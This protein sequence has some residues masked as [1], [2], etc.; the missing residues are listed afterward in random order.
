VDF[1]LR[2]E[3]WLGLVIIQSTHADTSRK[4]HMKTTR[5]H[6]EET[7]PD[8]PATM[9]RGPCTTP[10]SSELYTAAP[11][12]TATTHRGPLVDQPHI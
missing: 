8:C 3:L 6:Q 4:Q 12:S 7:T 2:L 5:R 9:H 10:P 11:S 1:D